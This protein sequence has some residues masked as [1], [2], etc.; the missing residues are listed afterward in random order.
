M[1]RNALRTAMLIQIDEFDP[2]GPQAQLCLGGYL[3]EL[4]QRFANQPRPAVAGTAPPGPGHDP[5]GV[6][7]MATLLG[8]P[9]GCGDLTFHDDHSAEIKR[10]WVSRESRGLGLGR[11]LLSHLERR[12]ARHGSRTV[13]SHIDTMLTE[14]AALYR[15]AGYLEIAPSSD[16]AHPAL[17]FVKTL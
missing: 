10:L 13:R 5:Q 3:A 11:R 9:V 16:E 2:A 7:L 4:D 17:R 8:E 6:M 1:T 15:A 14:A 12:A